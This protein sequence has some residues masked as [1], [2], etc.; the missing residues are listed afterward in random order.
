MRRA[1]SFVNGT[2]RSLR[3]ALPGGRNPSI[4]RVQTPTELSPFHSVHYIVDSF[5]PSFR[6]LDRF[7]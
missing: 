4:E 5:D 6:P 3:M 7:V 2:I 1:R